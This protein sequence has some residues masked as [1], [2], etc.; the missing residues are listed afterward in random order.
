M[1]SKLAIAASVVPLTALLMAGCVSQSSYDALQAQNQQLEAQNQQLQAQVA[2]LQREAS[3]V[4]AGDLLFPPG[5]FQLS[6]A[7][8]A[9]L[10]NNIVP[11]LTNLQNAKVV[12]YG[13]TDD[14]P[15]GPR[16]QQAG[17]NDNLTLSSRRAG[18]VVT[19]LVSQGVNPNIISA[20]GFGETHPV[21]PNDT[22]EDR[23]KNRRIVITIQGPGAPSA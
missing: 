11:K 16:L 3:F 7:G 8:Q 23:A 5:G 1:M 15:V 17:I 21:A 2:G 10:R 6:S 14:T 13:Y 22:P 12:V 4:E 19:Y 18:A 20:K 9:E